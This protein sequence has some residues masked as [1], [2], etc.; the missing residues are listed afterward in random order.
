[1]VGILEE[2]PRPKGIVTV[3]VIYPDGREETFVVENLIVAQGR[4]Y[5]LRNTIGVNTVEINYIALSN[6]TTDPS[7]TETSMPGTWVY[8]VTALKGHPS[9]RKI[10]W[11][12]IGL[13][14]GATGISGNTLASI[15]LCTG[16]NGSGLFARVKL[17][18]TIGL[19]S[20]VTVNI[21]Y[22]VTIS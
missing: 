14:G 5:M 13:D 4:D 7:D 11:S 22:E 21:G 20:G 15:G 12:V 3:E 18:S 17:P 19:A 10:R 9:P 8:T 1:M 16:S 2:M 6:D